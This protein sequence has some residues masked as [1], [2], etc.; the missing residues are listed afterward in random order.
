M[1]SGFLQK[2]CPKCGGNVYLDKD[3]NGWYE[4]CLQCSLTHYLENIGDIRTK[5][6]T[7]ELEHTKESSSPERN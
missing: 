1:K 6:K 7:V 2:R 3:F 5:V 4:K